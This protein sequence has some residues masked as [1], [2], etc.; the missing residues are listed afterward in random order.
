M[1]TVKELVIAAKAGIEN[2]TPAEAAAEIDEGDVLLLDVR[3]PEETARG[4]IPSAILVP[5]GTLEFA[6]DPRSPAHVQALDPGLRVIVYSSDGARSA[7]AAAI[8]SSSATATWP[9]SRAA[10]SAGSPSPGRRWR[11]IPG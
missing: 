1:T 2:L 5:R 11:R 10:S 4:I 9:T 7:L 8:R 3:E 6:A